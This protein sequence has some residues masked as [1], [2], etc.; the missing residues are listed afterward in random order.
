MEKIQFKGYLE[1]A[2]VIKA[3]DPCLV[4]AKLIVSQADP[5]HRVNQDSTIN[6]LIAREPLSFLLK[7]G[8]GDLIHILGHFNERHQL[9]LEKY[10]IQEKN[11][12]EI[13]PRLTGYPPKKEF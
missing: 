2:K 7:V 4:I 9:V 11:A 1:S 6:V 13:D 5:H 12:V 3:E 8:P 10:L